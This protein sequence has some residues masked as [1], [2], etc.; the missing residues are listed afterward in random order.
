MSVFIM[1]IKIKKKTIH[2]TKR[3]EST[4]NKSENKNVTKNSFVV[5]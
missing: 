2:K 4:P 5:G 3:D 1:Y